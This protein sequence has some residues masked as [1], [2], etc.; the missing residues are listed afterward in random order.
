[1]ATIKYWNGTA[2]ELAIVGKQGPVGPTGP[3]GPTGQ[4]T[5]TTYLY[6]PSAGATSISGV[7]YNGNTLSYT[8]GKEQVFLNGVLL[9]GGGADYTATT[10]TSITGLAAL[11]SGDV[12]EILV[13]G[14]FNAANNYTIAQVDTLINQD[15]AFALMLGGM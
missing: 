13:I 1:M 9:V 4:A 15:R 2:W 6:Y 5:L 14:T 10:G 8:P 7:D 12:V 3:T 11:A